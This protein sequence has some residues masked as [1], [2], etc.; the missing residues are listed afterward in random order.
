[1]YKKILEK[2]GAIGETITWTV[3]TLIII[4]ILIIFF[5]ISSLMAKLKTINFSEVKSDIEEISPVL[6]TKTL[7]AH[8]IA[9]NKNKESID[10]ILEEWNADK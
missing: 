7:I 2:R 1:M 3:A 6:E 4:G 10:K 8:N 9:E 5:V